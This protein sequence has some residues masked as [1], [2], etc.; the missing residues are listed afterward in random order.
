MAGLLNPDASP[1]R[2]VGGAVVR[3]RPSSVAGDLGIPT[4]ARFRAAV[5][6]APAILIT[7]WGRPGAAAP[8]GRRRRRWPR[9]GVRRLWRGD[10]LS[11]ELF[12]RLDGFEE[13]YF[14][15]YEDVDFAFR[16]RLI[17]V[18]TVLVPSAVV[19]HIGSP[20]GA[21][22]SDFVVRHVVR[23]RLRTWLRNM[24]APLLWPALPLVAVNELFGLARASRR[25]QAGAWPLWPRSGPTAETV[26]GA[27]G[28][29]GRARPRSETWRRR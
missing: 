13:S 4:T 16:A 9:R 28:F 22:A 10:V 8:G 27:P 24:P 12:K 3:E 14:C 11:S 7:C 25:G 19:R 26:A 1:P 5:L 17:G 23:N 20:A 21:A 29:N 2:L 18:R 6:M 15:Y